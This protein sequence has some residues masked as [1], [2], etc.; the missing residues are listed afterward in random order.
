VVRPLRPEE[1]EGLKHWADKYVVNGG[2]CLRHGIQVGAL[3][4][5]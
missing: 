5:T 3:C 2:Y 1:Q 4:A